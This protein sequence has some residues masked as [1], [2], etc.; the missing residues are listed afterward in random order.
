MQG[1]CDSMYAFLSDV[2]INSHRATVVQAIAEKVCARRDCSAASLWY[3]AQRD[4]AQRSAM[5]RRPLLAVDSRGHALLSSH[6][7]SDGHALSRPRR[8][9]RPAALHFVRSS[10]PWGRSTCGFPASTTSP[11]SPLASSFVRMQ[12]IVSPSSL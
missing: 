9:Q 8:R 2:G 4:A 3:P 5:S 6:G 7:G 11:S 10:L 1:M 12:S